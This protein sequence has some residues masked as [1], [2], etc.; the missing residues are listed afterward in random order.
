MAAS[1]EKLTGARN[2]PAP[3]KIAEDWAG[4]RVLLVKLGAIGDILMLLPAAHRLHERGARVDWVCGR[5]VA[6]LLAMYPWVNRIEVDERQLFQQGKIGRAKALAGV[7]RELAGRHYDLCAVLQYDR[8]YELL[9]RSV[10]AGRRVRLEKGERERMLIDGRWHANEYARVLGVHADAYAP[11]EAGENMQLVRPEVVPAL[12]ADKSLPTLEE[13]KR[14]GKRG[15]VALVP[16]G[17]KNLMRE[18]ALRRWPLANYVAFTQ[19][20]VARGY[21]VVLTGSAE[22]GWV[23]ES[24]GELLSAEFVWD[25]IGRTT[26]PELVAVYDACDAVVTHDTGSLHVAGISRAAVLALFGPT[27]MGNFLPRRE[28]V[29]GIWGGERLACR[30]CYDGRD[31]AACPRNV[32]M[33]DV[34]VERVLAELETMLGKSQ[35]V[36]QEETGAR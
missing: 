35:T 17:A 4:K 29:R 36:A 3:G 20:L 24:F 32:C 28:N 27:N 18:G 31:F 13:M 6:P 10:R 15:R 16:A 26:L 21:E 23:R 1:E 11:G 34:G 33:E 14:S 9:A 8:R 19:E 7:W 12:A 5:V 2:P 22:D 30:P 25:F